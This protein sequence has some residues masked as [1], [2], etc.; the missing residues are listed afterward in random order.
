MLSLAATSAGVVTF[1]SWNSIPSQHWLQLMPS[2]G[3][4]DGSYNA[5]WD[6]S[7]F[8]SGLTLFTNRCRSCHGQMLPFGILGTFDRFLESPQS[9][10]RQAT[11][12]EMPLEA[13]RS[14][15]QIWWGSVSGHHQD[16]VN[17][18]SNVNWELRFGTYLSLLAAQQRSNCT[19]QC[20]CSGRDLSWPLSLGPHPE[21]SKFNSF[22]FNPDSCQAHAPA[23][24]SSVSD[25]VR[26]ILRAM[27]RS[28]KRNNF[29]CR[30]KR[31]L[32]AFLLTQM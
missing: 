2:L 5:S 10:P 30:I 18:I 1:N 20:F 22:P 19:C 26:Q 9:D 17:S 31:I 24:E 15:T 4:P 28:S 23:L 32:A 16:A 7:L 11:S 3:P 27:C 13:V 21:A 6:W 14:A 25:F 8:V 29:S 12:I